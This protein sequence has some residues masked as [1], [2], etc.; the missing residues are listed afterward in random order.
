[1]RDYAGKHAAKVGIKADAPPRLIRHDS[2]DDAAI[3]KCQPPQVLVI[4]LDA[5]PAPG[6]VAFQRQGIA[7]RDSVVRCQIDEKSVTFA[8]ENGCHPAILQQL[9]MKLLRGARHSSIVVLRLTNL[10]P[11]CRYLLDGSGQQHLVYV[12]S[13]AELGITQQLSRQHIWRRAMSNFTPAI[14]RALHPYMQSFPPTGR[15]SLTHPR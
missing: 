12:S 10:C 13:K 2:T 14:R 4:G 9:P 8:A 1:M 3:S 6:K 5:H 15:V 11:L 7:E